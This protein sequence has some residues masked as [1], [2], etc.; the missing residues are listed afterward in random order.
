MLDIKNYSG[1][2]IG[3]DHCTSFDTTV[4][5]GKQF[6]GQ[7]CLTVTSMAIPHF[8]RDVEAVR[9]IRAGK[10]ESFG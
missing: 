5:D 4:N 1:V 10:T 7:F 6:G 2:L 8:K 3:Y 9:R